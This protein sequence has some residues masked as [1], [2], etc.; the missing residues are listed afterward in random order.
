MDAARV[1][2]GVA[3]G[4][5]IRLPPP[6]SSS[7]GARRWPASPG[8]ASGSPS[9]STSRSGSKRCCGWPPTSGWP[10]TR[11]R[12]GRGR[13]RTGRGV[14]GV[15]GQGRARLRDPQSGRGG[16]GGQRRGRDPVGQA[17][18]FGGVAL[19]HRVGRHRVLGGRG[20]GERGRGGDRDR[21]RGGPAHRR[22]RR[23]A[24]RHQPD[25]PLLAGVP[26]PGRGRR[27]EAPSPRVRRRRLVRPRRS[28]LSTGR[29]RTV[30]RARLRR[31]PG[32]TRSRCS[33]TR[34]A[35]RSGEAI[36]SG[37]DGAGRP[38]RSAGPFPGRPVGAGYTRSL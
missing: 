17:G 21:R 33:T 13:R 18:G 36:P 3:S 34:C 38:G 26:V 31:P 28:A 35:P 6:S 29:G 5:W 11:D 24:H 32:R 19:P 23:A 30:G 7:V 16:G 9:R 4:A 1:A 12:R 14:A 8:P 22:A 25:P 15:G 2:S 37:P 20:G 10:P 27:V